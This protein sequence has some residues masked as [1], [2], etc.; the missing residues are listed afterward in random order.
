MWSVVSVMTTSLI[1]RICISVWVELPVVCGVC[2]DRVFISQGAEGG[3]GRLWSVVSVV[4]TSLLVILVA[5]AYFIYKHY[6]VNNK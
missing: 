4:T 3:E 2:G 1:F 5:I 6:Q